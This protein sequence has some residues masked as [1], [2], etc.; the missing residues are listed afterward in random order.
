MKNLLFFFLFFTIFSCKEDR[1]TKKN[2]NESEKNI[3]EIINTYPHSVNSFT[4]GLFIDEEGNIFESTGSPDDLPQTE[5]L[6]GILNLKTGLIDTKKIL[7]KSIYFGEGIT[8]CNDKIFQLTYKN[9]IGFVYDCKTYKQID[10]FQF[11]SNEGWGLTTL[12]NETIIMSDGTELLSFIDSKKYNVKKKLL[13]KDKGIPVLN[14]NE[15]EYVKGFIYANI[16]TTNEVVKIDINTGEVS[17]RFDLSELYFDSKDQYNDLL[18]M[19]GI[20][21]NSKKDVFLITGK[22]WPKVYEIKLD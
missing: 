11:E 12:D 16:Y 7:D 10:T 15:L 9:K 22:F 8:K 2:Y 13:V 17:K 19:N 14:I 1:K 3:V 4:E 18:E 5:S 6:F 21:Y 20:A